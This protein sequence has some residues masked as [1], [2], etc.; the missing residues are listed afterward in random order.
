MP[1]E[2]NPSAARFLI[3]VLVLILCWLLG[4]YIHLDVEG[5]KTALR[6]YP[7]VVSGA[8]YIILYVLI[9][10]FLWFGPKDVF[11]VAGAFVFG[12]YL[13]ALWV[14]IAEMINLVIM[15]QL[16]RRLG[17]AFVDRRLGRR[18]TNFQRMKK[19][20]GV[21]GIA[22]LRLPPLIPIRMLDL[23]FGL[24]KVPLRRY[25]LVCAIVTFP[26]ILWQQV[27]LDVMGGNLFEGVAAMTGYMADHMEVVV[28]SLI[29]FVL[30]VG[31]LVAALI[32]KWLQRKE[33][34]CMT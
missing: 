15:F 22:A 29:Y 32:E 26:R 18:R 21:L 33:S 3:L 12:G 7:V 8:I 27:I 24:S 30:I 31:V 25:W 23:G 9:S 10:T 20:T 28:L 16:S 6:S 13:S 34:T 1:K 11:R 2:R 17:Q 14:W 5:L 19:T 4:Q